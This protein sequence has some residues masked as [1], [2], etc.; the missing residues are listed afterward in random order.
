MHINPRRAAATC[1]AALALAAALTMATA[2]PALAHDVHTF[3]PYTIA[4]GWLH[5]P[6]YVGEQNA[7]QVLVKRNGTPVT[8]LTDKALT[9]DVSIGSAVAAARA[10]VPTADPDTG[11]GT[12]GELENAIIPTTPGAYTFH[13]EGSIHGVPVDESVTASDT[14]FDIVKEP[15][16]AEFPTQVPGSADL[17]RKV[18]AVDSRAAAAAQAAA[19]AHDAGNRA[20]AVAIAGVVLAALGIGATRLVG[21]GARRPG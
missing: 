16:A 4:L 11:L 8:D 6:A 12:P 9:V 10:L 2:Q 17:S 21:R 15:A 14:T 13:L 5:E 18:G 3:G 20:L 7:V 1:G 19:D